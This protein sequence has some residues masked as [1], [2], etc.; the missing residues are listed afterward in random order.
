[1]VDHTIEA[2]FN[3]A[4]NA[5]VLNLT[6]LKDQRVIMAMATAIGGENA[7]H[8]MVIF[9]ATKIYKAVQAMNEAL[10]KETT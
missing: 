8:P 1:M 4:D 2:H 5:E 7:T 6:A 3:L 9:E 10:A